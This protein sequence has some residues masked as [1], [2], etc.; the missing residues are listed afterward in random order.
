MFNKIVLVIVFVLGAF[1][2]TLKAQST[3]DTL[4]FD[5]A[6]QKSV[7]YY[8]ITD[9][10]TGETYI[11]NKV[12][13]YAQI[14]QQLQFDSTNCVLKVEVIRRFWKRNLIVFIE[15]ST[16]NGRYLRLYVCGKDI[17]YVFRKKRFGVI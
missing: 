12:K 11:V 14:L 7:K 5:I 10:T 8:W 6:N 9:T 2:N 13:S 16:M 17:C 4:Y 3:N 1:I 15:P